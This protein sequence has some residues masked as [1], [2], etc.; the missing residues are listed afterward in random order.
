MMMY[1][2]LELNVHESW[3]QR[4]GGKQRN[5]GAPMFLSALTS[6]LHSKLTSLRRSSLPVY[7]SG[8]DHSVFIF[9]RSIML[10]DL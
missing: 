5:N 10:R 9:L 7:V 2:R 8:P 6:K 3:V 4:P 1:L